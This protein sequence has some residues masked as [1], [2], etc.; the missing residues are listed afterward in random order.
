[1]YIHIYIYVNRMCFVVIIVHP[2]TSWPSKKISLLICKY[3]YIYICIFLDLYTYMYI[4]R[5]IYIYHYIYIFYVP[6]DRTSGIL[7]LLFAIAGP[8][9]SRTSRRLFHWGMG[10]DRGYRGRVLEG[11]ASYM[12]LFPIG[13]SRKHL[14]ASSAIFNQSGTFI[15]GRGQCGAEESHGVQHHKS[16]TIGTYQKSCVRSADHARWWALRV[17]CPFSICWSCIIQERS[18]DGPRRDM[19]ESLL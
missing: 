7:T 17:A 10:P 12:V 1:M 4:F 2:K 16:T 9:W 8:G 15:Q 11:S 5:F 14:L 6:G 18:K 13:R 19:Y 3:L